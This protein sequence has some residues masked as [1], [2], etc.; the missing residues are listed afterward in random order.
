[1]LFGEAPPAIS[2]IAV[3]TDTD[4]TGEEATAFYTDIKL[5]SVAKSTLSPS[6]PIGKK[7]E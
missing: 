7:Q 2:G 4:N 1:M 6:V 3:M 5:R